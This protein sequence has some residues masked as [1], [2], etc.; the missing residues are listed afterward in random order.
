MPKTG[1]I[2]LAH[3]SRGERGIVEVPESLKRIPDGV[4]PLLPPGVEV[5]GAALQFNHPNLEE[6]VESLAAQGMDRI[7][8]MPYFL[9]PG[10]HITED[11]PQLIERLKRIYSDKKFIVTNPLGLEEHFIGSVVKRI[12]DPAHHGEE[13]V[14]TKAEL[15][16]L[17]VLLKIH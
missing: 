9:F 14:L 13:Q 12:D 16:V 10:R 11:I 15:T 7:A 2:I 8:I 6:A 17:L 3:G 1:V 5:I 4:K